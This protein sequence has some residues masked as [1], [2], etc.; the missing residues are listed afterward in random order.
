MP[1]YDVL[2]Y[3]SIYKWLTYDSEDQTVAITLP[4]SLTTEAI[5]ASYNDNRIIDI[6]KVP[7]DIT[8]HT[9]CV[10]DISELDIGEANKIKVILLENLSSIRPLFNSLEESICTE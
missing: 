7:V 3:A 4:L 10:A 1:P 6:I 9:P 2:V 8:A 5:I